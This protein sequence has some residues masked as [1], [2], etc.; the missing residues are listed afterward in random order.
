[1]SKDW[2]HVVGWKIFLNLVSNDIKTNVNII[3]ISKSVR[4]MNM[5]LKCP[6]IQ[7]HFLQCNQNF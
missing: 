4:V 7:V 6:S 3:T 2:K 5:N 1:M